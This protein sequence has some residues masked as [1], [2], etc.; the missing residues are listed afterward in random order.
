MILDL[1]TNTSIV[2]DTMKIESDK[3]VVKRED[4]EAE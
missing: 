1:I 4:I 2:D 3:T